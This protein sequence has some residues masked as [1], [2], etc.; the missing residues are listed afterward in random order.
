MKERL[1]GLHRSEG[2]VPSDPDPPCQSQVSQVYS[3]GED[4][5]VSSPL[6][7]AVHG[8]SSL[9]SSDGF[10]LRVP[11]SVGR[12]DASVSGRLADSGVFSGGSLPPLS[13]YCVSW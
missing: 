10:G 1:D 7:W 4:L 8:A 3:Q 13:L 5:A 9:H 2:C 6:L 12:P 11:P